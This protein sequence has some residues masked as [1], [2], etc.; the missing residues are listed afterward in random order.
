MNKLTMDY[1]CKALTHHDYHLTALNLKYCFL[2]FEY[3]VQLADALRFN[4]S[5]IKLDVS[6]NALKA[7]T[8]K[9]LVDSLKDNQNLTEIN[10]HGNFLN[11]DFAFM[12]AELLDINP[13]LYKVDISQNPI[14]IEGGK[15]ILDVLLKQN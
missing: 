4:K 11:D 14:G 1:L 13:V 10:F 3:F 12:L 6:N 2:D 8:A 5:L 9:Y 7:C 15:A